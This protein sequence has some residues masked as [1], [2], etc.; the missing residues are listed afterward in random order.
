MSFLIQDPQENYIHTKLTSRGRKLLSMGQLEFKRMVLSDREINYRIDDTGTYSIE[1]NTVLAPQDEHPMLQSINFDGS[2]SIDV[3]GNMFTASYNNIVEMTASTGVYSAITSGQSIFQSY[4]D[5]VSPKFGTVAASDI[6]GT[7]LMAYSAVTD[8]YYE[9]EY[10]NVSSP[11]GGSYFFF[12]RFNNPE[13]STTSL[14]QGAPCM[15]LVYRVTGATSTTLRTD[16]PIPNF[17]TGSE[18]SWGNFIPV[19][20]IEQYYG[21]APSQLCPVW[22]LNIV[23]T[24]NEIGINDNFSGYTSYGSI[25]YNG[26]KQYLG[27]SDNYRQ[28][29][30]I[31]YTNEYSGNP[32]QE[33]FIENTMEVEIPHLLW[34]RTSA[35]AGEA[36]NSGHKFLDY[37]SDVYFDDVAQ[38]TYT[39]L[40]DD[41]TDDAW[42]VGRVYQKLKIIAITDPELLNALTYKSN[43][44]F[45]LPQL[46]LNLGYNPP[47]GFTSEQRPGYFKSGKTYYVTY[48]A[49]CSSTYSSGESYGYQPWLPCGY[50]S[51]I[52]GDQIT[53]TEGAY[54]RASFPAKAFPYMRSDVG[55][56]AYSGTG[57][58]ANFMCPIIQEI[59]T[60]LD[61]G[62]DNLDS[63]SWSAITDSAYVGG[64]DLALTINPSY[65]QS[66]EFYI[67]K[68]E[69]TGSTIFDLMDLDGSGG[70]GTYF[71]NTNFNG[72]TVG[73]TFGNESMFFGNIKVNTMSTTYKTVF[74]IQMP[75]NLYNSSNNNTFNPNI[76]EFTYITEVG[77][78]NEQNEL[79]AV[80]KASRPIPKDSNT[81]LSVQLEM[82]F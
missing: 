11:R 78:L 6:D 21:Y 70:L 77:I 30:I 16:R 26:T 46:Q 29:G 36:E 66:H 14:A 22:N 4:F 12:L 40:K 79:V 28:I 31:H 2:Q 53:E 20:G 43:R 47:D 69:I 49:Q 67:G 61:T 81:F 45:T 73:L 1:S 75:D 82:D 35:N 33:Q 74:N 48:L 59:D 17:N 7:N 32:Y 41:S 38:T 72:S 37:N 60:E 56:A 76:D 18:R 19:D 42:V 51:K 3:S 50:V 23:R 8:T 44:N 63:A 55:M 52:V 80:G 5:L 24:S 68:H 25:E 62:V 71:G 34:H 65:A 54:L 10:T 13:S 57:W 39:L 9:N 64:E 15:T 58:N 27:F